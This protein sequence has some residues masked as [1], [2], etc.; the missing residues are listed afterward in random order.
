MNGPQVVAEFDFG[1]PE[2]EEF[3]RLRQRHLREPL[4]LDLYDEDLDAERAQRHFG[5]FD[6]D[7]L[8]A[9]ATLAHGS[10]GEA[11]LRQMIV[12]P[13]C[14]RHGLGRRIVE[15]IERV[16]D[17]QGASLLFL[18]AR[19]EAVE[20]YLGCGYRRVGNQFIHA[21]LPHVRMEKPL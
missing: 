11:Q 7:Q 8:V 16:A 3:C 18:N 21:T 20:F 12:R 2:Y 10:H 19:L 1:T 5:V 9:A 6:G 14:R 15:H 4:G 13:Q 17:S